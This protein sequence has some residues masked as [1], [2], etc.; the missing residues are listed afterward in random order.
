MDEKL[1]PKVVGD[2]QMPLQLNVTWFFLIMCL[3]QLV[4]IKY[5][6]LHTIVTYD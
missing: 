5:R 6:V 1:S 4:Q 2:M 3:L